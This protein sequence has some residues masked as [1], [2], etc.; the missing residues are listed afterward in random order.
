MTGL[1]HP[2][3]GCDIPFFYFEEGSVSPITLQELGFVIGGRR[4]LI[5]CSEPFVHRPVVVCPERYWRRGNVEIMCARHSIKC[6][7]NLEDGIEALKVE[8]EVD[9]TWKARAAEAK[10]G[11]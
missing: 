3:P 7:T 8:I 9:R 6:L 11:Q 10:G 4:G 2:R 5:E 1:I